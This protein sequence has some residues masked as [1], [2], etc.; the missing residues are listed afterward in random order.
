[1]KKQPIILLLSFS[2]LISCEKS[3]KKLGDSNLEKN[4]GDGKKRYT[5]IGNFND[6][7]AGM[8]RVIN[9]YTKTEL[10][11]YLQEN[12]IG[13]FPAISKMRRA[14]IISFQEAKQKELREFL[15]SDEGP[16]PKSQMTFKTNPLEGDSLQVQKL[17][18]DSLQVQL[19]EGT[20]EEEMIAT[21]TYLGVKE[22]GEVQDQK[23]VYFLAGKHSSVGSIELEISS[24]SLFVTIPGKQLEANIPRVWILLRDRFENSSS[25]RTGHSLCVDVVRGR[26]TRFEIPL[27]QEILEGKKEISDLW[28]S[29]TNVPELV[30]A[31]DGFSWAAYTGHAEEGPMLGFGQL[32]Q[33]ETP[34]VVFSMEIDL[35]ELIS[36]K[37]IKV[38]KGWKYTDD[39]KIIQEG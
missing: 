4:V 19:L 17:E 35:Y 21:Q 29:M 14:E 12:L 24:R 7:R 31:V 5:M 20:W 30:K 2:S 11:D 26:N 1:M 9:D 23:Y 18:G 25:Q 10:S 22:E 15:S 38:L 6:S 39:G 28:L 16:S 34:S 32:I 37:K 3:E 33:K 8:Q 27:P 13:V 36:D